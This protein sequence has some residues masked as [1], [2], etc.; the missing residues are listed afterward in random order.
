MPINIS[1]FDPIIFTDPI[2][3]SRSKNRAI[4]E[5]HVLEVIRF[6]TALRSDNQRTHGLKMSFPFTASEVRSI[7][8]LPDDERYPGVAL[9][10]F[11]TKYQQCYNRWG[12]LEETSNIIKHPLDGLPP[13]QY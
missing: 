1:D 7:I 2:L 6:L 11:I 10:L 5:T 3:K 13:N 9:F 8:A 12:F 4:G